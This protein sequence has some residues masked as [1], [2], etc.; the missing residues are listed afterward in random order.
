MQ[1]DFDANDP[2]SDFVTVPQGTY[3]CRIGEV[4]VGH[5]RG[6]DERW[7]L[8]LLVSRRLYF[9]ILAWPS[10]CRVVALS[11]SPGV[12]PSPLVP[13]EVPGMAVP[14]SVFG[15]SPANSATLYFR[16][17]ACVVCVCVCGYRMQKASDM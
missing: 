12:V 17:C 6:G 10:L 1:I 14:I 8:R 2:V 9:D 16:Q 11:P 13:A 4:R 7:S 3:L 5:T 15:G